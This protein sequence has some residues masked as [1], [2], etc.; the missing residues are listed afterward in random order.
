MSRDLLTPQLQPPSSPLPPQ[1]PLPLQDSRQPPSQPL[2]QPLQSPSPTPNPPK[3]SKL[4][5][6]LALLSDRTRTAREEL[7]RMQSIT[8][9][10]KSQ[11][12]IQHQECTSLQSDQQQAKSEVDTLMARIEA[13]AAEKLRVQQKLDELKTENSRL[14]SFLSVRSGVGRKELVYNVDASIKGTIGRWG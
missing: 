13:L 8:K 2:Q 11:C 3:Y 6:N 12:E 10:L 5:H 9:E 7:S 14:E 1:S 4:A